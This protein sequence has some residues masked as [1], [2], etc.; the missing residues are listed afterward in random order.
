MLSKIAASQARYEQNT[1][2]AILRINHLWRI[3]WLK[4]EADIDFQRNTACKS[5]T[6]REKD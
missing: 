4:N 5:E 1:K 3:H 6:G 2:E